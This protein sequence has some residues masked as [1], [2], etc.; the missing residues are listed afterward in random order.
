MFQTYSN[1][2]E[3]RPLEKTIVQK[4]E[5][6]FS[7]A[8]IPKKD[9]EE[10]PLFWEF[11]CEDYNQSGTLTIKITTQYHDKEDV[12]EVKHKEAEKAEIVIEP[13]IVEQ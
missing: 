8:I 11:L 3:Y 5:R 4:D 10:M 7:L 12:I 13:L 9:V 6:K 2:I 1:G